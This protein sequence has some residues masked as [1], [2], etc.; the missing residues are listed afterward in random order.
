LL[1]QTLVAISM[2]RRTR[3]IGIRRA[4]GATVEGLLILLSREFAVL[5]GIGNLAAWPL[6]WLGANYWLET[7]A[8]R[9]DPEPW[10]FA[11]A[12]MGVLGVALLT[13]GANV[14]KA[15]RTQPVKALRYQ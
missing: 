12:G 7:F 14:I 3:E 11:L 1:S 8:Y 15:A 6:A 2:L 13:V 10:L 9:I 4:L 5:V